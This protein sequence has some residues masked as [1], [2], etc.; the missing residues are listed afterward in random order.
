MIYL[1]AMGQAIAPPMDEPGK[2]LRR[3]SRG[4]PLWSPWGLTSID[5]LPQGADTFPR[6]A[7]L[8]FATFLF[9]VRFLLVHS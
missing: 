4:A 6:S 3:H 1:E 5:F 9:L 2:P 7:F 8:S